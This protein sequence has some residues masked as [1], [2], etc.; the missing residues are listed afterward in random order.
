MTFCLHAYKL[1][2]RR[3]Y[4]VV[5]AFQ[6]PTYANIIHMIDAIEEDRMR[7]GHIP[8]FSFYRFNSER[9]SLKCIIYT[10]RVLLLNLFL[11]IIQINKN[12]NYNRYFRR[13]IIDISVEEKKYLNVFY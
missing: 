1:E 13:I 11:K 6:I 7:R 4:L 10:L 8:P 2:N 3:S 12:N 9:S 5:N